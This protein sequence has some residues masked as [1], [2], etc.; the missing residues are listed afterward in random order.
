[1]DKLRIG[2]LEVNGRVAL[3]P[4]AGYTDYP[5]RSIVASYGCPLG[6]T[7]LV[8]ARGIARMGKQSLALLERGRRDCG[9]VGGQL[10]GSDPNDM[11]KAA[12]TVVDAGFDFVDLNLGCPAKKVRKQSAGAMLTTEPARMTRVFRAIRNAVE[13]PVT[14]KIR[15]GIDGENLNGVETACILAEEGADLITVH[16][17]TLKQMYGGDSSAERIAEIVGAVN[18]PVLANGDV[19]SPEDAKRLIEITGAV[20]VMIG[21]A[22]LREPH[23]I[24]Q[25]NDYVRTGRYRPSPSSEETKANLMRLFDMTAARWGERRAVKIFRKQLIFYVK[26]FTGARRL[27]IEAA[28]VKSR[29]DVTAVLGKV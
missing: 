29:D 11:A 8:S 18:V 28:S 5:F 21:R 20:G 25:A 24:S 4:L 10:F 9:V 23:L 12:Q 16:G 2:N 1:M 3:A 17:R 22:V 6:Y 7:P 26:G 13:V 15:I 19:K 27:R 14:A